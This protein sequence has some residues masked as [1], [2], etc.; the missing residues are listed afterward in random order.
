MSDDEDNGP[1]TEAEEREWRKL[2]LHK[3]RGKTLS[4]QFGDVPTSLKH[5]DWLR[6][7]RR[8]KRAKQKARADS[9]A[10]EG[11]SSMTNIPYFDEQSDP[12]SNLS[13]VSTGT[14]TRFNIMVRSLYPARELFLKCS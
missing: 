11:S 1:P 8:E 2:E 9:T 10:E 7:R 4:Y 13:D 12:D 14:I 6:A 3:K 5:D